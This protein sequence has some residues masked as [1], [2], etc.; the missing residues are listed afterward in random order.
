[1]S[2]KF[3]MS[4]HHLHRIIQETTIP[5]RKGD[6]VVEHDAGPLHV[7]EIFDMPHEDSAPDDLAKI[8][9]VFMTVG[10]DRKAAE[11]NRAELIEIL[12]HYPDKASLAAG[13]SYI[14]VGATVGSQDTAL[15]LFALGQVLGLWDVI[16]PKGLGIS[17]PAKAL[18]MAG[19]GYVMI[20]PW[21]AD[22][23]EP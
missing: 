19:V 23:V 4:L 10:V 11:E 6:P 14:T 1:M 3:T 20:S 18:E 12:K 22:G 7:T 21:K 17:D 16:T 8:D 13:P 15:R 2:L 5:L 9:V